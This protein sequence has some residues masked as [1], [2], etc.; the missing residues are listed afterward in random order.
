MGVEKKCTELSEL[1]DLE[2]FK[3][4]SVDVRQDI[5]Y[6]MDYLLADKEKDLNAE[7]TE[8]FARLIF[9][10]LAEDPKLDDLQKIVH[11]IWVKA[12]NSV[13]AVEMSERDYVSLLDKGFSF[14]DIS[15][16]IMNPDFKEI[17]GDLIE[18][19]DDYVKVFGAKEKVIKLLCKE[20]NFEALKKVIIFAEQFDV[21]S[22]NALYQIAN[23][24]NCVEKIDYLSKNG[25]LD[26]LL[27]KG[28]VKTNL[29][30]VIIG[31]E[32][33]EKIEFILSNQ[34]LFLIQNGFSNSYISQILKPMSWRGS[35]NNLLD[36]IKLMKY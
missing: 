1:P 5:R 9:D 3:C 17:M 33:K 31:S 12:V 24:A 22:A 8:F 25:V 20:N 36:N 23:S 26:K 16:L 7:K 2:M 27:S 28:F 6:L 4:L 21:F 35:I 32:W 13:V 18:K 10:V 29:L 14:R 30:Y 19:F 15:K 11:D 34:F